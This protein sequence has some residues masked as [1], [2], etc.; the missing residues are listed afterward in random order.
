MYVDLHVHLRGTIAAATAERLARRNGVP[1]REGTISTPGYGWYDFPSFLRVYD[2]V[3][4]AI[5]TAS[6]L[7]EVAHEHLV[8]IGRAGTAYVEF[9]LSPPHERRGGIPFAHQLAALDRAADQAR[10][11]TGIECRVIAT[12]VRHLG[13]DAAIDAARTAIA[14]RSPRLV[15][16]GLT[17]NELM[18][19]AAEFRPAFAIAHSEGLKVTAH[20][21]E[22]L[23][24]ETIL[25]AIEALGLDRVGHG[26][27]AAESPVVMAALARLG[28]PL[29]VCLS[30]NVALGVCSDVDQHPI[31]AL[32][33]AGC[34]VTLG[35]DDPA[36]FSTTP[37]REYGLARRAIGDPDVDARI[38]RAAIAAAF[39]DKSTKARLLCRL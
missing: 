17:G 25:P 14:C 31:A 18:H 3:A 28:I 33:A 34:V 6:D 15:G 38:T 30:S 7:E 32:A 27:R 8:R 23:G 29:E 21:G 26:V 35:T 20:A 1:M 9:M 36:F 39:C 24:P 37:A 13:P 16:F 11:L 12:A 5:R 19:E 2:E 10:E 4:A 22:H